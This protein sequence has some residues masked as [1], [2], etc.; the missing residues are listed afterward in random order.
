MDNKTAEERSRNMSRIRSQNTKPEVF[1]RKTLFAAG[2][3]YRLYDGKL[4]GKPDLVLKKHRTAVFIQGC[5]WHGHEGCSKATVPETRK[6]FWIRKIQGN[7]ARDVKNREELADEGW[8][9]LWIWE[10][11]LATREERENLL[12][13]F[14]KWLASDESFGEIRRQSIKRT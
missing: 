3:R 4:P 14:E 1:V 11:A 7:K 5:F 13:R 2:Y 10:F 6:D 9:V 8:R 12:P